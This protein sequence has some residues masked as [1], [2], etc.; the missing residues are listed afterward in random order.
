VK[1]TIIIISSIL[2]ILFLSII[3]YSHYIGTKGLVVKEY[4][5][6]N[7]RIPDEFHGFKIVHFSDLHY[8]TTIN[9]KEL[10]NIVNKI[11]QLKPDIVVFTGDF[12][13]KNNDNKINEIITNLKNINATFKK[14]A[15][16]GND[17][18]ENIF[19]KIVT[20]SGFINL[21]DTYDLIYNNSLEPLLIAGSSSNL[22]T[23]IT[24]S[25]KLKSTIDY[26]NNHDIAYRIVLLHEPDF[27]NEIENDKFHLALAGHSLGGEIR[28]PYI[29]ALIKP[30]GAQKYS[31]FEYKLDNTELF[32]NNGLGSKLKLRLNNKPSINL[33]RL[34]NK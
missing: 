16:S 26:I 27:I 18:N 13:E 32:I 12:I 3:L 11:N 2:I 29:G 24:I 15:I 28:L 5:I 30:K 25:Q 17:D 10:K 20:E 31:N 23:N 34:T 9:K 8:T 14:Y 4:K 6:L 33:Y 21:N 1:K 22:N 19:N 7:E